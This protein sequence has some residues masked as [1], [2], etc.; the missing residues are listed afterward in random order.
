MLHMPIQLHAV[1]FGYS[2]Y[3]LFAVVPFMMTPSP[4][5]RS[6]LCSRRPFATTAVSLVAL[7][8]PLA[9]NEALHGVE[10][11]LRSCHMHINRHHM[12][13]P[14]VQAGKRPEGP[15]HV[16]QRKTYIER[17]VEQPYQYVNHTPP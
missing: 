1:S 10:R 15:S 9:R 14:V 11:L 7:H 8:V 16:R 2:N 5:M 6:Q 13:K 17:A 4:F 3:I 12:K